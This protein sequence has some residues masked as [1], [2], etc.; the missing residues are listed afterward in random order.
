MRALI[1]WS[2][3]LVPVDIGADVAGVSGF[4]LFM[5]SAAAL[6]PLAY[7]IGEAT[8]QA[9]EHTGPAIAGLLNASFGNAPEL[10]ISLFAVDRGLFQFVRGSLVGSVVSN[11]LL[12]LGATIVVG[13][14]G[15]L[16]RSS[17]LASLAQTTFATVLFLIPAFAYGW[18]SGTT[19]FLPV[20]TLPIAGVLLVVYVFIT[21]RETLR[22]SR[23]HRA[24]RGE[25]PV[26]ADWSLRRALLML[27]G[28]AAATAFVSEVLTGSV[29]QFSRTVGL[30]DFFVAAVIVALVGNAAE[31]GGALVIASR[32]KLDLASEIAFSS[33]AQVATFVI[34]FVV[35]VSLVLRPLPLAFRP[36]ELAALA[37]AITV[38]GI[39]VIR[40]RVGRVEGAVLVAAYAAVAAGF[41]VVS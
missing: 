30:D 21:V 28:A 24:S 1:W 41:Y 33:S 8:E 5:L 38:P 16:N 36:F 17:G 40:G 6:V 23:A 2:L 29:E 15:T 4:W 18:R 39:A 34:P 11:L 3:L 35:L 31:H 7:V 22:H 27:A 12:V 10:I 25:L 37:V 13:R 20:A 26:D 14:R 19:R 32:G 9:G